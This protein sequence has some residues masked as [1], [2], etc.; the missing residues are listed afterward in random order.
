MGS[1]AMSGNMPAPPPGF[2]LIDN[3]I[4]PPP[5]GF[6][7]IDEVPRAPTGLERAGR[8]VDNV[9]RGVAQGA[10]LGFMDEIAAAARTG[11]GLWGNYGEALAQERAR[12]ADF[13]RESPVAATVANVAGGIAS[14]AGR[15]AA[16]NP[17]RA[18]SLPGAMARGAAGGVAL[19][20]AAGFGEGE[21]GLADRAVNAANGA[22][23]GGAIGGALPPVIRGAG[24]LGGAVGRRLGL[25]SGDTDAERIILRS[26]GRDGVTPEEMLQRSRQAGAAPVAV[27]DLGGEDL[28]GAAAAVAR[29]PGEGRQAASRMV[30]ERG[31][32]AQSERLAGM[33]RGTISG[34]DFAEGVN[35]V[36]QRRAAQAAPL[37]E[38]AYAVTLPRDLRLQRFLTDP[39]VRSGIRAGIESA[40]REALTE[41]RAF[42]LADL[43]VRITTR[44]V[45]GQTVEDF[46]LVGGN[47]PTRLIDAAKRGLDELIEASRG[48][49]GRATSRTRELTRLRNAMLTEVDRLNPAFAQA[50]A[51]FAGQS[52]LLDA[53]RVGRDLIDMRPSDFQAMIPD[54]RAMSDQQRE[55]L[56]LGLARGLLDRI[57]RATD[58]QELTRLNRLAGSTDLRNRIGLALNDPRELDGFIAQFERELTMAR[59]NALIGPRG[60]SQTAPLT[61]RVADLRSP[62]SGGL[63][64]DPNAQAQR[65]GVVRDML[66]TGRTAGATATAFRLGERV[67]DAMAQSRLERNT[68]ALAPMLFN[69]D[70]RAREEV[71]R[72]LIA[73]QARDRVTQQVINPAL[74]GLGRGGAVAGSLYVNE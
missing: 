45:N 41:D 21:G 1:G 37:Y 8:F 5:P 67:A 12:D 13:R 11:A 74:S 19:G 69:P 31:G 24:A 46:Q 65:G 42:N 9:V 51:A 59:N 63:M 4:P 29:L 28:A 36:A 60:G 15:V 30:A 40:R 53:A 35:A 66:T 2:T 48:E 52:E 62:P 68:N 72:A 27:A 55:F 54:I 57:E 47:T 56:R 25:T 33:V 6:T 20:G 73:R 70:Q 50:R 17:A 64:G 18:A 32:R 44:R 39:D 49:N 10:T 3:A 7:L 22:I 23:I 26:A 71:I 38:Q 61:E 43:G 14:P 34:D 16:L 58:A